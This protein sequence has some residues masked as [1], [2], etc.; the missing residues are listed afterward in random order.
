[1]ATRASRVPCCPLEVMSRDLVHVIGCKGCGSTIAEAFLTL[2][3]IPFDREEVNYDEE[4]PARDRLRSLNPLVQV[5]TLLMPDGSVLTETLAIAVYVNARSPDAGLIPLDERAA[6]RFWRWA[7][8]LVA[9]VYPTFLYG[10]DPAKW[11]ASADGQKQLRAS[12]DARRELLLRTLEAECGAPFFLGDTFSA[13][14]V[15][16][17]VMAHWRPGL[18]WF[19]ANTPRIAAVRARVAA[20]PALRDVWASNLD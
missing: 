15:Y 10:D 19:E 3:R 13:I 6:V 11:I 20:F 17:G 14:D 5:P 2:G 7:T 12:T 4:S 18:P 1:M 9:Q 16:L 8:V